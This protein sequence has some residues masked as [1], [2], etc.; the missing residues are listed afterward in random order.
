MKKKRDLK[1]RDYYLVEQ[2]ELARSR[3]RKLWETSGRIPE[4]SVYTKTLEELGKK[5]R[6]ALL[7]DFSKLVNPIWL[8]KRSDIE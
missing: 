6:Q 5:E 1:N 2:R 8:S 4:G 3:N 7:A